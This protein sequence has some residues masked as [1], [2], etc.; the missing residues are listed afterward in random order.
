MGGVGGAGGFVGVEL[1]AV[2]GDEVRGGGARVQGG[3]LGRG[4]GGVVAG[5]VAGGLALHR[6]TLRGLL[7]RRGKGLGFFGGLGRFGGGRGRIFGSFGWEGAVV[8]D[9]C[10][11]AGDAFSDCGAVCFTLFALVGHIG[12]RFGGGWS[13]GDGCVL[14][15]GWG[16]VSQEVAE[17]LFF[18]FGLLR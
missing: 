6:G 7:G 11:V 5:G 12:L 1:G 15:G 2:L 14:V 13:W 9:D 10:Y 16:V 3:K 8:G 18:L 17:R 4:G